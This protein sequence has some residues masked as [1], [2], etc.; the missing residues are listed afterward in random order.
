MTDRR[1][2]D[3]EVAAIFARATEVTAPVQST[4]AR[5][6]GLTLGELQEIG[7]EVGLDPDSVAQA[8]QSID[9]QLQ[10][11][12]RTV[13]GLP[14][15]VERTVQLNRWLTESEWEHLVVQL[16]E[17]FNARGSMSSSG[18]FRQWTNGNLQALLEPTPNGH[19]LRLRTIKGSARASIAAGFMTLGTAAAVSVAAA[20][21]HAGS[22]AVPGIALLS[23]VGLGMLASATLPLAR[24]A[25]L[26]GKQMESI[27]TGLA[28]PATSQAPRIDEPSRK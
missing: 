13:I 8:A 17:T 7:R 22:A 26:R 19:R 14:I 23:A 21:A 3:D 15:A 4:V 12:S 25:R 18:S 10:V 5:E 11:K 6:K 9:M 27:A 20:V 24:W 16:R 28:L 2:D 1:Y